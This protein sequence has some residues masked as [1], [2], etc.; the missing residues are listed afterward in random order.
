MQGAASCSAPRRGW[1]AAGEGRAA[2]QGARAGRGRALPP[3]PPPPLPLPAAAAALCRAPGAA[4]AGHRGSAGLA[5]GAEEGRARGVSP[6]R[7]RWRGTALAGLGGEE[8]G[9]G[10]SSLPPGLSGAP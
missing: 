9:L 1:L 6:R 8:P 4:W 7:Q 5:E 10:Q 3:T 2:R